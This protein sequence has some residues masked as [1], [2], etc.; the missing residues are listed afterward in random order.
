MNVRT[1][2]VAATVFLM[3]GSAVLRAADAKELWEENCTKCHGADGKGKT[4]M[5]EKLAMTL[6]LTD[7]K[8]QDK[9]DEEVIKVIREGVRDK[10]TGKKRMKPFE[11]LS[12]AD[13]K[14][15]VGYFRSL[16]K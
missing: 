15:L 3:A 6:D 8:A 16:K 4:K 12:D 7:A 13:V 1:T 11:D 2:I 5:A 9:K 14:L 10:D